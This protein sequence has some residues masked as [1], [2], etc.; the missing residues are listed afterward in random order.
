MPPRGLLGAV[1][2]GRREGRRG[3]TCFSRGGA[4]RS[5]GQRWRRVNAGGPAPAPEGARELARCSPPFLSPLLYFC[6]TPHGWRAW[7]AFPE[8]GWSCRPPCP[9]GADTAPAGG[10]SVFLPPPGERTSSCSRPPALAQKRLTVSTGERAGC[11]AHRYRSC[12]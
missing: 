1:V 10:L 8:G 2:P 5:A 12:L 7:P 9:G 3:P 4:G 11:L 6:P